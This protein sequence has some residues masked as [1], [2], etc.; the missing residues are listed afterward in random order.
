MQVR[1]NETS[2]IEELVI[3]ERKSGVNWVSD[4]IGNVGAFNDG[5]FGY[6]SD[7]EIRTCDQETYDWWSAYISATEEADD[8]LAEVSEIYGSDVV[9]PY[10]WSALEGAEFSDIPATQMQALDNFVAEQ[11]Q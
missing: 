3:I 9:Q 5:Q 7:A 11:A 2:K 6:D 8:R 4:M 1:I 10:I